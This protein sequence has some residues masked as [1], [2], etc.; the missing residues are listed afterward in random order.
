MTTWTL[1]KGIDTING[2][3]TGGNT[4]IASQGTINY[5]DSIDPGTGGD[6]TLVINGPGEFDLTLPTVLTDIQYVDVQTGQ[7]PITT[8]RG[9]IWGNRAS[10]FLR[11]GLDLTVT[12]TDGTA[13]PA[14]LNPMGVDIVGANNADVI[15]LED[16]GAR[17]HVV[18]GSAQETVDA[19][20][21]G[22]TEADENTFDVS[23]TTIGATIIG[24]ANNSSVLNV[25]GGGAVVM[26]SNITNIGVV[27]LENPETGTF[28]PNFIFTA[29][30]QQN[31]TIHGSAGNDTITLGDVLQ[32]VV[33]GAGNDH[34]IATA[35]EAGAVL[36]LGLGDNVLEITTGGIAT[37][38][39][40]TNNLTVAL[41][42][43]ATLTLSK[44]Q[45]ITA[46]G[47][48]GADTIIAEAKDQVITG[49]GGADTLIGFSGGSDIFYDTSAD[50]NG[51]TIQGFAAKGDSIDLS[52]LTYGGTGFS[53]AYSQTG[54]TGTLTVSDGVHSAAITLLG[55]FASTGF[56]AKAD[57]GVGTLVTYTASTH[58]GA[59]TLA[60]ATF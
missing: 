45:N 11:D 51:V 43:A 42:Q 22:L 52:D 1:H 59:A 40:N 48:G 49:N 7:Y 17:N 20:G 33:G 28:Q 37:L 31:L 50:L 36:Q 56:H 2:G 5:R 35:A 44:G 15:L 53:L 58:H 26:G 10:V 47:S 9:V 38:N 55:Q 21:A 54:S 6:N 3:S 23:A 19:S 27:N 60:A 57:P 24:G 34:V 32:K 30:N 8:G 41:D 46:V 12:V 4:V 18:V 14:N 39:A 13:N 16:N 29:N 25:F